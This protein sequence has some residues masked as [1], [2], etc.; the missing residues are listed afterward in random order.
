MGVVNF[1]ST[2]KHTDK[3]KRENMKNKDPLI[4]GTTGLLSEEVKFIRT[5][6]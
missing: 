6:T 1:L 4:G 5:Y 3:Q 2:Y